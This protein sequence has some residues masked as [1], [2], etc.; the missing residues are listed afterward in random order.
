[1][2]LK[3]VIMQQ[4]RQARTISDLRK[5][6][7]C[8]HK[9]PDELQSR[10]FCLGLLQPSGSCFDKQSLRVFNVTSSVLT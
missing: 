7:N 1:M 9:D 4:L 3:H 6:Q 2:L 8:R 5:E 10:H